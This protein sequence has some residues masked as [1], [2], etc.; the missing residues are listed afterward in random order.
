MGGIPGQCINNA[1]LQN[2]IYECFDRSDE[3]PFGPLKEDFWSNININYCDIDE[4]KFTNLGYKKGF[5]CTRHGETQCVPDWCNPEANAGITCDEFGG[6]STLNKD[7]C[8]NFTF[9]NSIKCPKLGEPGPW[10]CQGSNPGQCVPT[11]GKYG[12]KYLKI[13]WV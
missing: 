6:V 7:L 11:P 3:H 2:N 8:G 5:N 10:R 12:I 9:W 13:F 4:P 1:L